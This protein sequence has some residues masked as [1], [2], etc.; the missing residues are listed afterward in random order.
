MGDQAKLGGEM[1]TS[2]N[3]DVVNIK[4]GLRSSFAVQHLRAAAQA[5]RKAYEIEQANLTAEH[6]PWF[7][8]MMLFVPVS[9]VMAGAAL[10]AN[11]NELI[12]DILDRPSGLSVARPVK[13]L[14][15]E[16]KKRAQ[17]QCYREI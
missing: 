4:L 14:L 9:V 15:E 2:E 1:K 12:Q 6:G 5:A 3:P 8:E 16:L 17:G 13:L 10:E 7:D 11:A